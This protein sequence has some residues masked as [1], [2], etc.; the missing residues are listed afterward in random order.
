MTI[1]HKDIADA[2]RHEPRGG[3]TAVNG[4]AYISNGA[5]SGTWIERIQKYAVSVG[6][7][8]SV[9]AAT[10]VQH[11]VAVTGVAAVDFCIA[12]GKPTHQAG[13]LC[14]SGR[15]TAINEVTITYTNVTGLAIV[16]TAAETYQFF[17][18]NIA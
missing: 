18:W 12:V 6:T 11:V 5:G 16:P 17:I 15:V 4:T 3:T 14:V 13:L 2:E 9:A 10:S 7:P 1:Q 8:A